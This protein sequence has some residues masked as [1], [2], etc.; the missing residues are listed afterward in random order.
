[1]SARYIDNPHLTS[2]HTHTVHSGMRRQTALRDTIA[3]LPAVALP[4]H[5]PLPNPIKVSKVGTGRSVS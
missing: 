1:M 5:G 3:Y 4:G 2:E